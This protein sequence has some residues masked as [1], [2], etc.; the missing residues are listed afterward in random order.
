[1]KEYPKFHD[2]YN[3]KATTWKNVRNVAIGVGAGLYIYN[4]IDAAVAPGRRRVI[5]SKGK[6][7]NYSF[8]PTWDGQNTALAFMLEF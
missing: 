6:N 7:Y 2:F 5:V 3:N 1:M 4:L 8:I